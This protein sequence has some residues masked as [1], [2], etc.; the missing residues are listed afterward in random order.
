VQVSA[1]PDAWRIRAHLVARDADG[2]VAERR[3]EEDVPRDHV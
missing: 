2:L 1:L 3:W